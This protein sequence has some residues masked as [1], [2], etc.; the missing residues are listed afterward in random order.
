M[1]RGNHECRN[2][3]DHFTFRE[4]AI[5]KYDEEV[6]DLIMELF[7]SL[8]IC[9]LADKKYFITHGGISPEL[10]KISKINKIDR[11]TE[12]PM[13]GIMCDLMWADPIDETDAKKYDFLEN[14]ER[15]CSFYF[16]RKP[17]KKLIDDNNLMTIVRAHQVQ[18]D[19]Y[20]M[21]RW[22]GPSSFPYVITIF[23]APNY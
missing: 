8:P 5:E 7:D 22:D 2:M 15:D 16:G 3:T 17:T 12:I 20:K 23:S 21:H 14:K 19:G 10:K 6:Y 1:L 9:G 13:D 11:F 4:E 18:V